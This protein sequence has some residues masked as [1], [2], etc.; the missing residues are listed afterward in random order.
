M[1]GL[2]L[3]HALTFIENKPFKVLEET[4]NIS[5]HLQKCSVNLF[6]HV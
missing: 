2:K 1:S 6:H 3:T 5:L 4:N